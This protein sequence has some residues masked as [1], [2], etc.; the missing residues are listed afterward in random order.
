MNDGLL[1]TEK[2]VISNAAEG[3][4]EYLDFLLDAC[5]FKV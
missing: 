1:H 5:H 3:N 2:F 4:S